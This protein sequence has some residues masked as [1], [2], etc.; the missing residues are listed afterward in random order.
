MILIQIKI[1]GTAFS[2][3][4]ITHAFKTERGKMSVG[5]ILVSKN[6]TDNKII[7]KTLF[8]LMMNQSATPAIA[9]M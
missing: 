6:A 8:L 7:F 3:Y 5:D 9:M 1:H 2:E 4:G